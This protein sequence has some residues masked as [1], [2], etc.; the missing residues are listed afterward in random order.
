M[1][2]FYA[3]LPVQREHE[4]WWDNSKQNRK[5]SLPQTSFWHRLLKK[6]VQS[7]KTSLTNVISRTSLKEN[8]KPRLQ[9]QTWACYLKLHLGLGKGRPEG[10]Q[11]TRAHGRSTAQCISPTARAALTAIWEPPA[12]HRD[13]VASH[14]PLP[15][16]PKG[17][18]WLAGPQASS[19]H[20]C[21]RLCPADCISLEKATTALWEEGWSWPTAESCRS[22]TR[23]QGGC[24][25]NTCPQPLQHRDIQVGCTNFATTGL[26]IFWLGFLLQ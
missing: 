25:T 10:T 15:T 19:S 3:P 6:R 20:R 11:W 26:L 8:R 22:R 13:P 23:A 7:R 17:L 12:P 4:T 24:K 9:H 5:F 18:L 2:Q 1:G 16:L 21:S 14:R